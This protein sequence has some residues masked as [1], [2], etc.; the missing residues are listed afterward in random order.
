[1]IVCF[2]VHREVQDSVGSEDIGLD[3]PHLDAETGN[4]VERVNRWTPSDQ[5]LPELTLRAQTKGTCITG[6]VVEQFPNFARMTNLDRMHPPIILS[7]MEC[8]ALRNEDLLDSDPLLPSPTDPVDPIKS[9]RQRTA[10]GNDRIP[11]PNWKERH[12]P[13]DPGQDTL[14]QDV[15]KDAPPP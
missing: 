2:Q 10:P 5:L 12:R 15:G 9:H 14:G 7:P 4:R 1:M 3:S 8:E 13:M 11:S 6:F